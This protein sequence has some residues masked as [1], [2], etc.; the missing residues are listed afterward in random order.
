MAMGPWGTRESNTIARQ[1]STAGALL[2]ASAPPRRV[3]RFPSPPSHCFLGS[4]RTGVLRHEANVSTQQLAPQ[5]HPRLSLA[6]GDPRRPQGAEEPPG[7]RARSIDA[8]TAGARFLGS[9]RSPRPARAPAHRAPP[10]I[11]VAS[12]PPSFSFPR[13]KRLGSPAQFG[14]VFAEPLRSADR[15]FTVLARPNNADTARLGLTISRR[16]AK[17]AVDRNRLKRLARESFRQQLDLPACDFVVLAR[18][19]AAGAERAELRASL[20]RHFATLARK[21]RAAGARDG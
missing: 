20:D 17:R 12:L 15:F 9:R 3:P 11:G 21:A 5:T 13:S 1:L 7:E 14:R 8:L 10:V 2:T 16:A 18:P 19:P 4:F 6:H